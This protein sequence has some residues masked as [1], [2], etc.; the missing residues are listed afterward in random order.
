MYYYYVL[1]ICTITALHTYMSLKKGFNTVYR[2]IIDLKIF[3]YIRIS[4]IPLKKILYFLS[5]VR[6]DLKKSTTTQGCQIRD[7]FRTVIGQFTAL[8]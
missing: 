8:G 1:L 6:M 4:R 2:N 3:K 5:I 7:K